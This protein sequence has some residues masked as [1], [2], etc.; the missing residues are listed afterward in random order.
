MTEQSQDAYIEHADEGGDP[1]CW[2]SRVCPECGLFAVRE[3]PTTCQRC[4]TTIPAG[5]D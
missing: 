5:D 3:P 4:G 2:L 1:V